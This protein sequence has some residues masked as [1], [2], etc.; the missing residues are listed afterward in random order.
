MRIPRPLVA[1]GFTASAALSALTGYPI[2]TP[3]LGF[4]GSTDVIKSLI[5]GSPVITL[6]TLAA[7]AV[8]A[9]GRTCGWA[10]PWG[11]VQD[12]LT[13]LGTIITGGKAYD[14]PY[15]KTLG[16]VPEIA[17]PLLLIA[18]G[19]GAQF[20]TLIT[21]NPWPPSTPYLALLLTVP[22]LL[23]PRFYC[24]YACPVGIV[25]RILNGRCILDRIAPPGNTSGCRYGPY[26][27]DGHLSRRCLRCGWC[28]G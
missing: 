17:G 23:I 21:P 1:A 8:I 3:G 7:P 26:N 19:L 22:S 18:T 13:S 27:T 9:G 14:L 6:L 4:P 16:Y 25:Y 5:L 28:E 10:C 24:R 2:P 15:P 20:P 12:L 11:L